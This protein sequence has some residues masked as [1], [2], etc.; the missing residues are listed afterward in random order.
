MIPLSSLSHSF[1]KYWH[2]EKPPLSLCIGP[3]S[4]GVGLNNKTQ[5][6]LARGVP[7]SNPRPLVFLLFESPKEGGWALGLLV[8]PKAAHLPLY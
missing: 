6:G 1:R 7:T 4:G 8:L 5:N 2:I 3:F